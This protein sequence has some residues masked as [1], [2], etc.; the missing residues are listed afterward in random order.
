MSTQT[1]QTPEPEEDKEESWE[2]WEWLIPADLLEAVWPVS[3]EELATYTDGE[4]KALR[5]TRVE[6]FLMENPI[7]IPGEVL[8]HLMDQL[9]YDRPPYEEGEDRPDLPAPSNQNR[10]DDADP[11]RSD[12]SGVFCCPSTAIVRASKSLAGTG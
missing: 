3:P 1:G 7:L 6:L 2:R 9:A 4:R 5:E 11:G 8:G 12:S 10:S